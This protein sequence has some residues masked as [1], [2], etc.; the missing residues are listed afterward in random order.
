MF[1]LSNFPNRKVCFKFTRK[2]VVKTVI[3]L[4][5]LHKCKYGVGREKKIKKKTLCICLITAL[6]L[7]PEKTEEKKYSDKQCYSSYNW[8]RIHVTLK[9][10]YLNTIQT[11]EASLFSWNPNKT[12]KKK[13]L[14]LRFS[15]WHF[16]LLPFT[17]AFVCFS[18]LT[19]K[20][21]R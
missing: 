5:Y 14:R 18:Q 21:S 3:T 15:N 17:A 10:W 1:N 4:S 13:T 7:V 11:I 6:C 2:S 19:N 8:G 9:Y 20:Q 12:E 16:L